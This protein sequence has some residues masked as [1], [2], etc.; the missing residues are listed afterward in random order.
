[1][2]EVKPTQK[3]VPSSDIKDL[4][5][6]SG[7]LD[8]WATS[9][10]R[11]YIDRFGNCHLTAAGMEWIFNELVTK[12]K[13]E[14]EQALLAA[15]YAPAGTFQ[16]GA[17][18]VSR[19]GTV[20]WKLPD[21]DG[22]HYRWDGDLPKQVPVGSTPQSTGGIRKGA[23][24]SV[25]DASL[26][27]DIKNGDGSLIGVGNDLTLK[28]KLSE[29]LSVRDYGVVGD[30]TDESLKLQDAVNSGIVN[31]PDGMNVSFS[32]VDTPKGTVFN[33]GEN[34]SIT[35]LNHN[36]LGF[37]AD[38]TIYTNPTVK[39]SKT[40]TLIEVIPE[41]TRWIKIHRPF[42]QTDQWY[43]DNAENPEELGYTAEV[44][45]IKEIN[46]LQITLSEPLP[47][48]LFND[49]FVSFIDG[50]E[51][52]FNGG[53]IYS[54]VP[55]LENKWAFMTSVVSNITFERTK[56]DFLGNG[57]IR[58]NHAH[59]VKLTECTFKNSGNGGNSMF[60]YGSTDCTMT[61]CEH[62][63][64]KIYDAQV[65]I[66]SGCRR[67]VSVD[68]KYYLEESSSTLG[69]LYFGAKSIGCKSVR[70][71]FIGGRYGVMAM[72]GAQ[73]F[74]MISPYCRG[75]S[76]AGVFIER[77]QQFKVTEPNIDLDHSSRSDN[78]PTYGSIVIKDCD[79]YTLHN[80]NDLCRNTKRMLSI[81][82][83]DFNKSKLRHGV[84]ISLKGTGALVITI[85][86]IGMK[87]R[88]TKSNNALVYF[89]GGSLTEKMEV[90][91]CD[92][93]SME[94]YNFIDSKISR[95]KIRTS[96]VG[97]KISGHT[98]KWNYFI[99]NEFYNASLCYELTEANKFMNSIKE[100]KLFGSV[101]NVCNFP[102]KSSDQVAVGYMNSNP[103][104]KGFTLY[105]TDHLNN[106]D[107]NRTKLLFRHTG[108][109]RGTFQ[110]WKS[111]NISE[112]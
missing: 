58:F 109:N 88:F 57:G 26:R 12:F 74:E 56:F 67:V 99:E 14:S 52:K 50:E 8:I 95:N 42:I 28:D 100:P 18:V 86:T 59:N 29:L 110:D 19:N 33:F 40:V 103:A 3:P 65:N 66:Y 23:W 104:T 43:I 49:S 84:D 4:F 101:S 96:G 69:G 34:S 7:L 94:F 92:L 31:I 90:T 82:S 51:T 47:F 30:G 10:E 85:P 68:G 35:L 46:G 97:I 63:G 24:V 20:L 15:G 112:S 17:E 91:D 87:I 73:Q 48:E 93:L 5:F 9:L 60:A 2:R 64:A 38:K 1:M 32:G 102:V 75:Q 105:V 27:F 36:A 108:F 106:A 80:D 6:N 11:K 55:I 62:Y 37:E 61:R 13:I 81:Y 21:G 16:E 111:L 107:I 71:T 53:V 77:C 72:F 25:G 89:Q 70:D 54:R 45:F 79:D 83:F 98:A 76:D 44:F 78:D 39:G 41:T 22:D